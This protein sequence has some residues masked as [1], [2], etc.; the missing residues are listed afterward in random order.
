ML[1]AVLADELPSFVHD[2]CLIESEY[3]NRK[4]LFEHVPKFISK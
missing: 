1:K 3:K 4:L 2:K